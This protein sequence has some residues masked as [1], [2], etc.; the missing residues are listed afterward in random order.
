MRL[1][2]KAQLTLLTMSLVVALELSAAGIAFFTRSQQKEAIQTS[3]QGYSESLGLAISAQFF[4]RYGDV[5]AFSKNALLKGQ[6]TEKMNEFLNEMS[7]LYGI[8][9]V[10]LYVDMK[11][12]FV[13]ATTKNPKGKDMDI[14]NLKKTNFMNETWFQSVVN[15]KLTEDA[16]K[17]FAGTLVENPTYDKI[18]E[19]VTGEKVFANS[20]SAPVFDAHGAMIGVITNRA[21]FSW[22]EL[23]L[24]TKYNTLLQSGFSTANLM[25]VDRN[26]GEILT[27]YTKSSKDSGIAKV[28]FGDE[29]YKSLAENKYAPLSWLKEGKSGKTEAIDPRRKESSS[30][31]AGFAP[32]T[33][34]K[35][36]SSLGWATVIDANTSEAYKAADE[37]FRSLIVVACALLIISV[38]IG[39]F[40]ASRI[41]GKI[42]KIAEEIRFSTKE[43]FSSS[44][45]LLEASQSISHSSVQTASSI[46][47][48]VASMEELGSMTSRNN[49]SANQASLLSSKSSQEAARGEKMMGELSGSIHEI[50][51]SSKKIA[52]ITGVI[53]DIAFQTNLLA[54]NA[55]VEAARAG[56]QGKGFAV[57]AEAVRN[58]AQKSAASAKEISSLIQ[59][60]VEKVQKGNAMALETEQVIKDLIGSI[61]KVTDINQEIANGSKEQE[62]GIQQVNKAMSEIDGSSQANAAVAE[63]LSASASQ[64]TNQAR[65]LDASSQDLYGLVT[66]SD[67]S[68]E[69]EKSNVKN[70]TS[71]PSEESFS[72]VA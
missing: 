38:G 5:Q 24:E 45:Q 54:L 9:D 25:V 6:D 47:T 2:L 16:S 49:E 42:Q 52:E 21:N 37:S 34:G 13:A 67:Y 11:G 43:V 59:E 10:I 71:A 53:D 56:E 23:E 28:H 62:I 60:T 15:N 7:A 55:A 48:T 3:F 31:V 63:E 65:N 70:I 40:Y 27:A 51:D 20:F 61:K 26:S 72:K 17:N 50:S 58:L 66:G 35:F 32:I 19:Q 69:I 1:S 68:S 44:D 12:N 29:G 41:A 4:E 33:D 18:I 8:Y 36:V 39:W 46:E 22:V 64:L 14:S 57:V 30:Q